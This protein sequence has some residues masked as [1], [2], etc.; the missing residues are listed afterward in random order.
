MRPTPTTAASLISVGV[1]TVAVLAGA[2]AARAAQTWHLVDNQQKDLRERPKA[3]P[4]GR[5]DRPGS[6]KHKIN[7][8][9]TAALPPGGTSRR[10]TPRSQPEFQRRC[11]LARLRRGELAGRS[12]RR[13]LHL[14]ALGLRRDQPAVGAESP[15]G[16]SRPLP[17]AVV[18]TADP[19]STQGP[20]GGQR[21]APRPLGG[22][23]SS[24][25]AASENT[26][27]PIGPVAVHLFHVE[28]AHELDDRRAHQLARHQDREAGRVGDH[29]PR[30]DQRR[31]TAI[32]RRRQPQVTTRAGREGRGRTPRAGR[33]GA[34]R[35]RWRKRLVK[36]AEVGQRRQVGGRAAYAL[37]Q[38]LARRA[39]CASWRPARA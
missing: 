34:R 16:C 21:R 4:A 33:P 31:P 3:A 11:R 17:K 7:I 10:P 18:L 27:G 9:A 13:S 35:R 6:W 12:R 30:R 39:A 8:G 28:L 15:R 22:A 23:A 36:A 24:S 14:V 19:R 32:A 38:P 26:R 29:E 37:E 5:A 2:T 25:S 20:V 1:L